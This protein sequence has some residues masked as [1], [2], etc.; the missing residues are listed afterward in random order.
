MKNGENETEIVKK[1][2]HEIGNANFR[3]I[4]QQL[5]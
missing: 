1:S 5:T 3:Y 2:I 4:L